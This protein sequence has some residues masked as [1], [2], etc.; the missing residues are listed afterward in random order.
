MLK[1]KNVEIQKKTIHKLEIFNLMDKSD[2][3]TKHTFNNRYNNTKGI[4]SCKRI[5]NR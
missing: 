3:C 2:E 4:V 1:K 5:E